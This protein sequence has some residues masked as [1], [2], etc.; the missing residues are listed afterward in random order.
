MSTIGHLPW[1]LLI[2]VDVPASG[3]IL[4]EWWYKPTSI[5]SGVGAGLSE[6]ARTQNY[7]SA[8]RAFTTVYDEEISRE[9]NVGCRVINLSIETTNSPHGIDALPWYGRYLFRPFLNGASFITRPLL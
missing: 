2:K 4:G 1:W 5:F 3:R 9:D 8:N 6:L 7:E